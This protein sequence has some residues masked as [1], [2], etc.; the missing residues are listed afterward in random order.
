MK[1][2]LLRQ[3]IK[4]PITVSVKRDEI[5]QITVYS[6]VKKEGNKSIGYIEITS[7][8]EDTA[9][10]FKKQLKALEKKDIEGL[11]P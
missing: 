9:A 1:L 3:G 7:F 2:E 4:E 5:P 11:G 8:S 10:E 6:K